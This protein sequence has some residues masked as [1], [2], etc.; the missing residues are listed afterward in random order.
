[1]KLSQKI[2]FSTVAAAIDLT[3]KAFRNW[4]QRYELQLISDHET[5]SWTN[6]AL[7]DVAVLALT[8]E[9]VRW[10]VGVE[11]AN[12]CAILYLRKYVG[13]IFAYRNAPPEALTAAL[14]QRLLCVARDPK[15]NAAILFPNP[16]GDE[17]KPTDFASAVWIT[18]MLPV[19]KAFEHILRD[20]NEEIEQ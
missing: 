8:R 3:P 16:T 13:E 12:E 17:I 4:L 2:R 1:M 14:N 7:S 20:S 6:F 19:Q 10:G 5:R 15:D 18:P 11:E 9:M